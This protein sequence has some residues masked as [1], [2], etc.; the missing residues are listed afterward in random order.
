MSKFRSSGFTLIELLVVIAII[1]ILAAILFPVFAQAKES[2]K[3]T[4]CLA[5]IRQLN[6]AW[7]MY[8]TDYDDRWVSTGK[9]YGSTTT[10]SGG[11]QYDFFFLAQPYVKNF[12]IFFCP[13]R[14]DTEANSSSDP[15]GRLFGYGMNYGPYHNRA[16]FGAFNISTKYDTAYGPASSTS[17]YTNYHFYP[18][19]SFG[20]FV[21]PAQME[22]LIDTGDD[23]QYTN[24]P[25]DQCNGAGDC[26]GQVRHNFQYQVG[27]AD[28][29]ASHYK[30]AWYND[31]VDGYVLEPTNPAQMKQ[32][33]YDPAA[34]ISSTFDPAQSGSIAALEGAAGA[35]CSSVV[36]TVVARRGTP[37]KQ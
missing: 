17:L 30:M 18:G 13:D 23:P 24:A 12:D 26:L 33:C 37:I 7:I 15:S 2:A 20:E 8:A 25:Y 5:N 22:T 3:K 11:N 31:P 4:T 21:T 16:G 34:K 19:R 1:A 36:D 27:F 35:T 6:N 32:S 10:Q 14:H 29:H 28:G 9:Q